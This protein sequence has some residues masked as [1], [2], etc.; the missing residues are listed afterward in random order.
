MNTITI[1]DENL[2]GVVT[3]EFQLIVSTKQISLQDLIRTRV[4]ME[5]N[6]YNKSLTYVYNGLVNPSAREK[7]LNSISIKKRPKIDA[8]KEVYLALDGFL[9]N[10]YFV[11]VDNRQ[12]EKLDHM[13]EVTP[14]SEVSFLKLTQLV[15]G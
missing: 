2:K 13:I 10:N 4:E 1:K 12:V 7:V 9:K 8:E 5:V 14:E 3:R 6:A 15:G 11:L